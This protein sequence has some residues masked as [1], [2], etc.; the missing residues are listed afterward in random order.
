MQISAENGPQPEVTQGAV[1]RIDLPSQ[2]DLKKA[3]IDL[4]IAHINRHHAIAED[5]LHWLRLALEELV[6][7]AIIHGHEGDPDLMLLIQVWQDSAAA[8][9]LWHIRIDDQ[10]EGFSAQSVPDPDDPASLLLERGRGIRLAG[11]GVSALRY[12]R[13]GSSAVISLD[14]SDQLSVT[15]D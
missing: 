6:T 4:I 3:L 14:I 8:G 7:N 5:T 10:G 2:I 12:Y 11:H 1:L 15:E 13:G 9:A